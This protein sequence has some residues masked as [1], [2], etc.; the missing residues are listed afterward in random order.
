MI[1]F[2][3]DDLNINLNSD[4]I[5][6]FMHKSPNWITMGKAFSLKYMIK[7]KKFKYE[8]DSIN[9]EKSIKNQ[10]KLLLSKITFNI[11]LLPSEIQILNNNF[12]NEKIVKKKPNFLENIIKKLLFIVKK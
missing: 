7:E 4:T 12:S 10:E 3:K 11:N 1:K 6:L 9:L 8:L 5:E 2:K